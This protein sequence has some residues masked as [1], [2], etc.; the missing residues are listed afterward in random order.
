MKGITIT[1]RGPHNTGRTTVAVLFKNFLDENGYTDVEVKDT[2]PLPQG[3][4]EA[5]P[6]RWAKNRERPVCIVVELEQPE[7]SA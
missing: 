7:R 1:I 3:Q 5:F 2:H 4:K 6:V